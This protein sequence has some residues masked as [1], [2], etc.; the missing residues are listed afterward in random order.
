MTAIVDN[1]NIIAGLLPEKADNDTFWVIRII[2][3]R[4]DN[5]DLSK[6][7]KCYKTYTVQSRSELLY[8]YDE[9]V[10]NAVNNRAR[11]YFNPNARSWRKVAM[12]TLKKTAEY[13]ASEDY[14]SVLLAAERC[15]DRGAPKGYKKIWV[16]DTD[17]PQQYTTTKALLDAIEI[18]VIAEVPT[19]NGV[20][21][22]VKPFNLEDFAAMWYYSE[23]SPE[24]KRNGHTLL[25]Y[26]TKNNKD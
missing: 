18:P 26:K 7:S 19:V 5:P 10:E 20:H 25:Y 24:I 1:F 11:A 23:P 15:L 14:S 22:L 16:I 3:R 12:A 21:L 9:I 2:G 4:K 17:D 8:L 13:I 6:N